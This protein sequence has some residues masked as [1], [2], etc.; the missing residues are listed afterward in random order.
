MS[1]RHTQR[2]KRGWLLAT[3]ALTVLIACR[4][5]ATYMQ[6]GDDSFR[7]IAQHPIAPQRLSHE[8]SDRTSS[9]LQLPT[10]QP[11]LGDP[12]AG[13]TTQQL[14]QF[15]AGKSL[16][17]RIF[18]AEDGLGPTHNL[19]SCIACHSN[20]IGGSS[21]NSITMFGRQ[22]ENGFDPLSHLGG[23]LLQGESIDQ[24]CAEK[25]P[26]EANVISDRISP[27]VL[28]GGLIEA[29]ADETLASL[30]SSQSG[31][32]SGRVNWVTALEDPAGHPHRAGRFGFK[33][34]IATLLTFTAAASRNELGLTNRF[35]PAENNINGDLQACKPYDRFPDPELTPDAEG[36]DF[37][38]RVTQFQQFLAPPPQTPRAGMIGEQVFIRIGCAD[39][40]TPSL[41]TSSNHAIAAILRNQSIKPYSDFLLHDMG[42][43]GDGI[44]QKEASPS[45]MRTTPLWGFRIRFPVLHDGRV[46][47]TT[48]RERLIGS[49]RFHDGEAAASVASFESLSPHDVDQLVS[50]I[51][52]LGRVEFDHDGDNDV[53][54]DDYRFFQSCMAN[55]PATN[56]SP[57]HKCA[58]ADVDQD[59]DLDLADYCLF[60]RATCKPR[61]GSVIVVP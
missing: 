11:K 48:V 18:T 32:I 24:R 27:S 53:D 20:P 21:P 36:L 50:F 35:L 39:C 46:S 4:P 42:K 44:A 56:Y 59:G 54:I 1:K 9:Q 30:A 5:T 41:P 61:Y 25:V 33:S 52:S 34:Q 3:T 49:I 26:P 22:T 28:G 23:P 57:A 16:F 37:V 14:A 47:A 58:I 7:P 31:Q 43:L 19:H 38:D 45:E 12:L 13:L 17:R 55:Q 2:I 51:D 10:L 60:Q 6:H 8:I 15:Q 29:I 40:H